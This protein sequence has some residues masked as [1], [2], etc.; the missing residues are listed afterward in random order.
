MAI[1]QKYSLWNFLIKQKGDNGLNSGKEQDMDTWMVALYQFQV[2]GQLAS[3]V[4]SSRHMHGRRQ[5]FFV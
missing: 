4:R 3:E 5:T 1:D 2:L